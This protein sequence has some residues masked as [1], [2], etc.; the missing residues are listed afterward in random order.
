[1]NRVPLH[2]S[3]W[4]VF[5]LPHII[6]GLAMTYLG[7]WD[8]CNLDAT[9]SLKKW[10]CIGVCPILLLFG[11]LKPPNEENPGPAHWRRRGH[12][13]QD[14]LAH[15]SQTKPSR[16]LWDHLYQWSCQLKG[17]MSWASPCLKNLPADS[18]IQENNKCVLSHYILRQS[19]MQ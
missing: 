4:V 6:V 1:M 2:P 5:L 12:V 14:E 3:P 11:T 16:W 13:E 18:E 9:V 19:L 15:W 17:E 8:I 10:W 7:W